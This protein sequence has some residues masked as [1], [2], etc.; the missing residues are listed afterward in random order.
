MQLVV[1]FFPTV[2]SWLHQRFFSGPEGAKVEV[3]WLASELPSPGARLPGRV[4]RTYLPFTYL[5]SRSTDCFP[6]LPYPCV[7]SKSAS[8]WQGF[9]RPRSKSCQGHECNGIS[10]SERCLLHLAYGNELSMG[11]S[12][13]G[14]GVGGWKLVFYA[15]S[16]RGYITAKHP[17]L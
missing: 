6:I 3:L 12:G 2:Y 9:T 8:V 14:S 4:V 10:V 7:S 13:E 15:V 16:N 17:A 1:W 5:P 11:V